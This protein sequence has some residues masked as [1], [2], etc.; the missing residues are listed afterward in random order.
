MVVITM[1]YLLDGEKHKMKWTQGKDNDPENVVDL[2]KSIYIW[3]ND[4]PEY[5]RCDFRITSKWE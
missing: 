3:E 5:K 1:I 2:V 4:H